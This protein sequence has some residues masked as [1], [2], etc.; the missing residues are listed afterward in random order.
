[1]LKRT[2]TAPQIFDL[3]LRGTGKRTVV[4]VFFERIEKTQRGRGQTSAADI[5]AAADVF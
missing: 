3:S 1:M 4:V 5:S 2:T